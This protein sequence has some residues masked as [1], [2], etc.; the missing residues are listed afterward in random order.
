MQNIGDGGKVFTRV[1]SCLKKV[2]KSLPPTSFCFLLWNLL[3]T[4]FFFSQTF[5]SKNDA[6]Y[7]AKQNLST[8]PQPLLVLLLDI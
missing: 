6:I 3:K 2:K 1:K 7:R 4:P 5:T 8:Y